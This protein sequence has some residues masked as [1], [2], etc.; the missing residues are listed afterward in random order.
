LVLVVDDE[1]MIRGVASALLRRRLGFEV[2]TASDGPEALEI[3]TERKDEI[4]LVMLDL[5]MPGMSGWQTL[6]ALRGLRLDI[7][8]I[9]SS[10]YDEAQS[11]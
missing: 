1:A 4:S 7:P 8:V 6:P 2:I 10:G 5:G 11:S 9:L 3:F